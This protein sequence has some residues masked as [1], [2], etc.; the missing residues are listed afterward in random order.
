MQQC[1]GKY[2]AWTG[3]TSAFISPALCVE[4]KQGILSKG[5]CPSMVHTCTVEGRLYPYFGVYVSYVSFHRGPKIDP[6]IL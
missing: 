3:S 1:P 6:N 4:I 2:A 5:P